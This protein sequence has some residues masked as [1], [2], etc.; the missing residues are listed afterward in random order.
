MFIKVALVEFLLEVGGILL[1]EIGS[2]R[3]KDSILVD[4]ILEV[5]VTA[6][7]GLIGYIVVLKLLKVNYKLN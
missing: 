2:K 1:V 3:V 4:S 6:A 5:E 7:L